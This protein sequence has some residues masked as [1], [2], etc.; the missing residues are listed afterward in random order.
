MKTKT[1]ILSLIVAVAVVV[2]A[3]TVPTIAKTLEELQAEQNGYASQ[4]AAKKAE[5]AAL[6]GEISKIAGQV[7]SYQNAIALI[8]YEIRLL[9]ERISITQAE[10]DELKSQ[11]EALEIKI[12]N[13]KDAL[14]LTLRELYNTK[15]ISLLERLAT[16]NSLVSFIDKEAQLDNIS[17][18]LSKT[19]DTI[20]ADK[21][22]L[23]VKQQAA[24]QKLSDLSNQ[25]SEQNAKKSEQQQ[26]LS[27][28]QQQQSEYSSQK[29]AANSERERLEA[30]QRQ[31]QKEIALATGAGDPNKGGYPYD[32]ECPSY[33]RYDPWGMMKC[34]CVSYTAW[35]VHEQYVLGQSRYDMPYWG[36]KGNAN[37]WYNNAK[38]SGIPHG[39]SPKVGSVGVMLTGPYGHVVWVERV[40]SNG[41]ITVSEYN[42]TRDRAYSETTYRT[43]S[44]V[45]FIYFSERP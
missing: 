16:S 32:R 1:K 23:E 42:G 43:S 20:E 22:N 36:G 34:Q 29:T 30:L 4:I 25:K 13:N 26:L 44:F 7:A 14:G 9:D 40:N 28:S 39:T 33:Y 3:C 21:T 19:V 24:E 35:K 15:N 41:T 8:N 17:A 31:V 5:I 12:E 2:S 38:N 10:Y 37:L 45:G 18:E 11:I 6:E 27:Y